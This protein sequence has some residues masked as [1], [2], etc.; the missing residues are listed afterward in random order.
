M[1]C[2]S[3]SSGLTWKQERFCRH[4]VKTGNGTQSAIKAGYSPRT[5]YAIASE[6]L[7][8]PEVS[9]R[10][11]E[12]R[13]MAL[14]TEEITPQWIAKALIYELNHGETD[15]ARIRA[16]ELLGKWRAMFTEKHEMDVVQRATDGDLVA[17]LRGMFGDEVADSLAEKMGVEQPTE[18]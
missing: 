8:K 13:A 7:R 5:A 18:H 14:D 16:L 9:S 12:I 11:D 17:T 1:S 15:G 4:Y 3:L 10:I 6:N 2:S